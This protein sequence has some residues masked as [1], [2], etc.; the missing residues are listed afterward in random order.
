[1]YNQW[2]ISVSEAL[3]MHR[4]LSKTPSKHLAHNSGYRNGSAFAVSGRRGRVWTSKAMRY[5]HKQYNN[6]GPV[7]SVVQGDINNDV[8]A[9]DFAGKRWPERLFIMYFPRVGS[10]F[11]TV[12]CIYIHILYKLLS[13]RVRRITFVTS[14]GQYTQ[15]NRDGGQRARQ[16]G[17]RGRIEKLYPPIKCRRI[18][19]CSERE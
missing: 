19:S 14:P 6:R 16:M 10:K 1:M 8:Y 18:V 2:T 11:I 13:Q 5:P 9:I 4:S 17:A 7:H 15:Y 3:V 12:G